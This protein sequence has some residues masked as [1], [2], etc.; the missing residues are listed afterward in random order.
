MPAQKGVGGDQCLEVL[1]RP[2]AEGLGLRG[3]ASALGVSEPDPPR[4]ELGIV[5]EVP[6]L[7]VDPP[8]ERDDEELQGLRKRRHTGRA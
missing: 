2:T 8:G 5:D 1:A 7:L 6:L 4:T 3:Q